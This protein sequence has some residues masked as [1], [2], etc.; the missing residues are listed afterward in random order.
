[1]QLVDLQRRRNRKVVAVARELLD[2]AEAGDLQGLSFV[3]KLGRQDHRAGVVGDYQQDPQAAVY[4][5][6]RM[7][8][9]LLDDDA[10]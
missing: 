4:A 6:L 2:L 1:M 7:N 3:A 5:T 10:Q 9:H 8:R